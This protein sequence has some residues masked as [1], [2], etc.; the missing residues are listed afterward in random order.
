MINL[1]RVIENEDGSYSPYSNLSSSSSSS[2]RAPSITSPPPKP[3]R[4]ESRT[5]IFERLVEDNEMSTKICNLRKK[6]EE[7]VLK[8]QE[9]GECQWYNLKNQRYSVT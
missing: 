6:M 2:D 4:K 8:R 5:G 9:I 3:V 7:L 1:L